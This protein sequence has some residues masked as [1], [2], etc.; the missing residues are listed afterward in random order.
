MKKKSFILNVIICMLIPVL[1]ACSRETPKPVAPVTP[2]PTGG[3]HKTA[4]EKQGIDSALLADMFDFITANK[5]HIRSLII[6]RNRSLVTE[7]YVHPF[8]ANAPHVIHSCSKSI[9]SA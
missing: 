9:T 4:P 7:A 5:Y 1:S 2:W 3:W 6:I 8:R